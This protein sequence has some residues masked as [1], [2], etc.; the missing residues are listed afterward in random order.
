VISEIPDQTPE[1]ITIRN[2]TRGITTTN[3]VINRITTTSDDT[4]QRGMETQWPTL[5]IGEATVMQPSTFGEWIAEGREPDP[6]TERSR[7]TAEKYMEEWGLKF[8]EGDADAVVCIARCVREVR[9]WRNKGKGNST[10]NKVTGEWKRKPPPRITDKFIKRGTMPTA[11]SSRAERWYLPGKR[12]H[13]DTDEMCKAF[14]ITEGGRLQAALE[15]ITKTKAATML[16]AAAHVGVLRTVIRGGMTRAGIT[17][18]TRDVVVMTDLCSGVGTVAEAME[19]ET[20][21]KWRYARAAEE[22]KER[23]SVLLDAWGGRGLTPTNVQEDAY[24]VNAL[25]AAPDCD[26]LAMTP[27]CGPYSKQSMTS[28]GEAMVETKKV[29]IMMTYAKR[30]R[31]AVVVMESVADLLTSTRMRPCGEE[32]E[33]HLREALPDYE[34]RKQVVDPARHMGVPMSRERAFWVGTRP[35]Q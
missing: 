19:Q 7:R 4:A 35:V 16:G 9:H 8:E 2:V 6:K 15:R 21:G 22:N 18:E 11:V 25:D 32:I 31:P 34:W 1:T 5:G 23:A 10:K 20:K 30:V 24:D 13:C 29:A 3:A 17:P 27:E 12:R 14:G 28:L 33:R 26:V